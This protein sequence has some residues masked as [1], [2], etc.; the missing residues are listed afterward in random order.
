MNRVCFC[1]VI[2]TR[3][4]ANED[5]EFNRQNFSHTFLNPDN[6]FSFNAD[7][8]NWVR[9]KKQTL[10]GITFIAKLNLFT[11]GLWCK[12]RTYDF[13]LIKKALSSFLPYPVSVLHIE[14]GVLSVVVSYGNSR[15]ACSNP[16][17]KKHLNDAAAAGQLWGDFK[18][19]KERKKR[20][21][22][23]LQSA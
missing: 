18:F 17:K 19:K 1:T 16:E 12:F 22:G 5:I 6:F 21:E 2:P 13:K 15:T 14:C 10:N 8:L 4:S 9:P 7:T 20:E 23:C 11:G 3:L